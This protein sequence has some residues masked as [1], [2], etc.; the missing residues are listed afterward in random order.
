[1]NTRHTHALDLMRFRPSAV[2]FIDFAAIST[3][4][5]APSLRES[6]SPI[7]NA[8]CIDLHSTWPLDIDLAV[9][10]NAIPQVQI[11]EALLGN[12]C[13]GGHAFEMMD[14]IFRQAHGHRF[15]EY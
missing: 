11:D 9:L 2:E 15:F 10:C 1:V 12:S 14:D 3:G 8:G 7:R 4:S 6:N 5:I 13:V